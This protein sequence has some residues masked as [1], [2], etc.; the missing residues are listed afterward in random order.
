MHHL[1]GWFDLHLLGGFDRHLLGGNQTIQRG[2]A[3]THQ[4][5]GETTHHTGGDNIVKIQ[6][7]GP[8][9]PRWNG[10]TPF[11]AFRMELV[12]HFK[13]IGLPKVQW[14]QVGL[15]FLDVAPRNTLLAKIATDKNVETTPEKMSEMDISWEDFSTG[16]D[17]L[18]G[19]KC[20]EYEIHQAIDQH[21]AL[22]SSRP[23]TIS[24][25]QIF[26]QLYA[27]CRQSVDPT[28]RIT[29][30][31][32]GLRHDLY[33]ETLLTKEGLPW[34]DYNA[35]RAY[36]YQ[37]G[38]TYDTQ[39]ASHRSMVNTG[40][41]NPRQTGSTK[42]IPDLPIR[43]TAFL[44]FKKDGKPNVGRHAQVPGRRD[45]WGRMQ[46]QPASQGGQPPRQPPA[47]RPD[48]VTGQLPQDVYQALLKAQRCAKYY[49]PRPPGQPH[50]C[51][52]ATMGR[53]APSWPVSTA[54]ETSNSFDVLSEEPIELEQV[55]VEPH[56]ALNVM[57]N[58]ACAN[59]SNSTSVSNIPVSTAEVTPVTTTEDI[60]A[61]YA[62]FTAWDALH[63]LARKPD[64]SG[65]RASIH[66]QVKYTQVP[67]TKSPAI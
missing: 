14:G 12:L 26:D 53:A 25:L 60:S 17:Q 37:I 59:P 67:G 38:P 11:L 32:R 6:N 16:M 56:S 57:Q 15:T 22:H 13:A 35:L 5:G 36:L 49:G 55:N 64:Q 23:D 52:P 63:P 46:Q 20:S 39:W 9:P 45:P 54:L 34:S 3:T 65:M 7:V 19:Q 51:D 4:L 2:G 31:R 1:A 27:L 8:K 58:S 44:K 29:Q 18:F 24:Y 28:T 10:E 47:G 43:R 62:R 21:T 30:L 48:P 50:T 41:R 33:R 40:S 42:R 61:L 66:K